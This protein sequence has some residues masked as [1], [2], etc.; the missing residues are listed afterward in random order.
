[1]KED[2]RVVNVMQQAAARHEIY[3]KEQAANIHAI[4]KIEVKNLK[5]KLNNLFLQVSHTYTKKSM[6]WK[7]R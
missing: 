7:P 6:S 3:K 4:T 2:S 5:E 1:M